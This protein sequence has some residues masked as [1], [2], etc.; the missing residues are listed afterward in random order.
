MFGRK[1]WGMLKAIV[2]MAIFSLDA[3][4]IIV[5]L[6]DL[7]TM[8]KQ[9][10]VVI[11][12]YVGGSKVTRD[13]H[14]RNITLSEIEVVDGL[15]GAKTGEVITLYQVGGESNGMI[16]PIIGGQRYEVGS[17]LIF[18][19]LKLGEKFVSYGAGQGKLDVDQ[20]AS[21]DKVRE[22]LGDVSAVDSYS[23]ASS[24]P[25]RPSPLTFSD[26]NILKDEIRQMLKE[27]R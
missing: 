13:K 7:H 23:S 14:G 1:I 27:R 22:D 11:H 24:S 5:K 16:S 3:E 9:S 20:N 21:N 15:Y 8:A 26:V 19:G 18:F 17:E 12:G 6:A 10:D 25:Y 4:A 2:F